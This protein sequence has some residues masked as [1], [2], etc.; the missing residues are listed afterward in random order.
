MLQTQDIYYY[1]IDTIDAKETLNH[2][3]ATFPKEEQTVFESHFRQ[4]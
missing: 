3:I 4:S 1:L 2:I